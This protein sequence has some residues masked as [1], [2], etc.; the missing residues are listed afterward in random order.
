MVLRTIRTSEK[1]DRLFFI[2]RTAL[3]PDVSIHCY[4]FRVV[5]RALLLSCGTPYSEWLQRRRRVICH[6]DDRSYKH[7]R[8]GKKLDI[9]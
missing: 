2:P 5:H 1:H 9:E 7:N 3:L 4:S 8:H 6:I